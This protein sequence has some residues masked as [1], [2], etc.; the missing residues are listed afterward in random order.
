MFQG[1][2]VFKDH[3]QVVFSAVFFHIVVGALCVIHAGND[4]TILV[5]N[6]CAAGALSKV[7]SNRDHATRAFFA[8]AI[9]ILP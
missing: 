9:E 3:L 1:D 8:G 7:R 6:W 5:E 2:G 4:R